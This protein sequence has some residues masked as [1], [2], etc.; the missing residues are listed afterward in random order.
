[1]ETV[2]FTV[3]TAKHNKSLHN[4]LLFYSRSF[5][6][7]VTVLHKP[8]RPLWEK[9]CSHGCGGEA[10]QQRAGV[11][12]APGMH[13][14]PQPWTGDSIAQQHGMPLCAV[15][16]KQQ[17]CLSTRRMCQ[18]QLGLALKK[19]LPSTTR[20]LSSRHS[21]ASAAAA[22]ATCEVKV[23]TASCL[24]HLFAVAGESDRRYPQV[25]VPSCKWGA[26]MGSSRQRK[27]AC[28]MLINRYRRCGAA[29]R[30]CQLCC[31]G[32]AGAA[33]ILLTAQSLQHQHQRPAVSTA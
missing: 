26:C 1:V 28:C 22:A 3:K 11:Q 15:C 19:H 8:L 16:F 4:S 29:Q 14:V 27:S 9:P 12:A 31:G 2:V 25:A 13:T 7:A 21:A 24:L 23:R 20:V 17:A 10:E 18:Q 5:S 6:S 30:T 33:V 32:M